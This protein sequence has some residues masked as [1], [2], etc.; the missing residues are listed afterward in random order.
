MDG[1][2]GLRWPEG[3]GRRVCR[4]CAARAPC[5]T[6]ATAALCSEGWHWGAGSRGG[7]GGG[8]Q[9][10]EPTRPP[11]PSP[12]ACPSP[13]PPARALPHSAPCI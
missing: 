11:P 2:S 7:N 4:M 6:A 13:R 5:V 10:P 9:H 3:S 12:V 8:A 1:S